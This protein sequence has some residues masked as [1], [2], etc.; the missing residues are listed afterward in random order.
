MGPDGK[1]GK[2]WMDMQYRCMGR[3]EG[4]MNG[5]LQEIDRRFIWMGWMHVEGQKRDGE[6]GDGHGGEQGGEHEDESVDGHDGDERNY[7]HWFL[8]NPFSG[9]PPD[10][11]RMVFGQEHSLLFNATT[12]GWSKL[13]DG[14]ELYMMQTPVLFAFFSRNVNISQNTHRKIA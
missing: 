14:G 4:T 3:R 1:A 9:I 7:T 10:G 6:H 2:A 11:I 5:Y 13:R 12:L 8:G